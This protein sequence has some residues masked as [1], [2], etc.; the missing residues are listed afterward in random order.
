[1]GQFGL[2]NVHSLRLTNFI[3]R[4]LFRLLLSTLSIIYS[5]IYLKTSKCLTIGDGL[6]KGQHSPKAE[7]HASSKTL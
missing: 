1:M 2:K 7:Y 4:N 3:N 5:S 6:N